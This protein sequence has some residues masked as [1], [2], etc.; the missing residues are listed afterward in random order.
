MSAPL[1][2][3]GRQNIVLPPDA[4]VIDYDDPEP[5]KPNGKTTWDH[6]PSGWPE[7]LE[8]AAFHGI[9]GKYASPILPNTEADATALLIQLLAV[10][11]NYIGRDAYYPVGAARHHANLFVAIVGETAHG[12]KGTALTEVMAGLPPEAHN[13]RRE[14][15]AS[16]LSS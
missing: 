3:G 14:C 7:P 6:P 8:P 5:P 13:W 1:D 9:A 16:G 10:V 12:R 2:T 4:L 15:I 11:G